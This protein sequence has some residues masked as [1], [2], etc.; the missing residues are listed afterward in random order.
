MEFNEKLASD[1]CAKFGVS[2]KLINN[3]RVR[4]GI[5]DKYKA[6]PEKLA[7]KKALR[8]GKA[9]LN[10]MFY[11][12]EINQAAIC[13]LAEF[14]AKR[15]RQIEKRKAAL[16][17]DEVTRLNKE[18]SL[19]KL[20]IESCFSDFS[21]TELRILLRLDTIN[22][23]QIITDK[24]LMDRIDK[25]RNR[26]ERPHRKDYDALHDDYQNFQQKIITPKIPSDIY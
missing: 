21:E 8:A 1:I 25:I 13:E 7:K 6:S 16:N 9:A 12:K 4:G 24:T 5:P 26:N 19:I 22:H 23:F 17:H 15:I 14:S 10:E 18:L 2:R 11:S 20:Q 3:W